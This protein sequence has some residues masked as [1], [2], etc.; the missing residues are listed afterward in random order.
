M[1][2]RIL[3]IWS[4]Y[5][6]NKIM[7]VL[8]WYFYNPITQGLRNR[9]SWSWVWCDMVS[10]LEGV[11][12]IRELDFFLSFFSRTL[13]VY[14]NIGI[15]LKVLVSHMAVIRDHKCYSFFWYTH[16]VVYIPLIKW[17]PS[18]NC[19]ISSWANGTK[20]CFRITPEHT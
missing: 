15:K 13:K 20:L 1:R 17:T 9:C 12:T 3:S 19:E 5:Y 2:S 10:V 8:S 18:N 16:F 14:L 4:I 7:S 11:R 6:K